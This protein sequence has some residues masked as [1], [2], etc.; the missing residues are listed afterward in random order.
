M[1]IFEIKIKRVCLLLL[2]TSMPIILISTDLVGALPTYGPPAPATGALPAGSLPTYEPPSPAT[3]ALPA[4]ALPTYVPPAS[5]IPDVPMS[6]P[7]PNANAIMSSQTT[8]LSSDLQ[9]FK[10][11]NNVMLP[12]SPQNPNAPQTP[13]MRPSSM[14]TAIGNSGANKQGPFN[15]GA[16]V[17]KTVPLNQAHADPAFRQKVE[18]ASQQMFKGDSRAFVYVD[19]NSASVYIK[20]EEQSVI[21]LENYI[22]SLD[23]P[24]TQVRIDAII[25]LATRNYNFDIGIDWSGIYNRAQTI[26][27]TSNPF[28]FVGL[29]GT[30]MEIPKPTLPLTALNTINTGVTSTGSTNTG[31]LFVDPTNFALNLFNKAFTATTSTS[32]GNSFM[33]VPFV[34]G[35]PDIN[36]RRLNLVLNAAETESKVKIVSRPSVLTGSG[37][38]AVVNIGQQLPMQQSSMNQST[39]VLYK[40]G[41]IVYK[42]VGISLT[43][44][45]VTSSDNKT[46]TLD[47]QIGEIDFTSGSTQSN[48]DGIMTNP[49]VLNAL[50]VTNKVVLKSGQTT[51][52][53][54]LAKRT[55]SKTINRIPLLYRVPILGNLFQATLSSD[56][57]LEQ[58][59]FI[60]PTV[61]EESL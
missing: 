29:G 10:P 55:D 50:S 37:Q 27:E 34:F 38:K 56:Q 51:V 9:S 30:L 58:F 15:S 39:G 45:P 17:T 43:V 35:G 47:I 53:G 18:T 16:V 8:K 25:L 60:T 24:V 59:I 21:D 57:E 36:L 1:N 28:G 5:K 49:P 33:Q 61:I 3:V 7:T 12:G 31:N 2:A 42:D 26:I 46:V 14:Q 52:I 13:I 54:G 44:T 48:N 20:G 6:P 32:A 11:L 40:T 19:P 22:L 41:Q 23:K 4:G